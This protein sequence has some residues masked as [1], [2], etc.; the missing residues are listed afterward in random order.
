MRILFC[1]SLAL[2]LV[3]GEPALPGRDP[4]FLSQV[5]SSQSDPAR[6]WK[7]FRVPEEGASAVV[8]V[9]GELTAEEQR[10]AAFQDFLA[11]FREDLRR[12]LKHNLDAQGRN[13]ETGTAALAPVRYGGNPVP[14]NAPLGWGY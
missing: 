6:P 12:F 1:L 14:R 5:L 3:A 4:A 7:T 2:G 10:Q 11:W 13:W 9:V 8:E